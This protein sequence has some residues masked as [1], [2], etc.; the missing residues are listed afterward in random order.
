MKILDAYFSR[1]PPNPKAFYLRP[2]THD[3]VKHPVKTWFFDMPVGVN[4]LNT[5]VASMAKKAGLGI[6]YTNHSLR[7]T[8]ACF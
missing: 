2:S 5:A 3:P 4:T 6:R 7:A 8:S 1:I